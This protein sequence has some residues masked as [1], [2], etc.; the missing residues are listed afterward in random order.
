[1]SSCWVVYNFVGFNKPFNCPYC[2]VKNVAE[3]SDMTKH[4]TTWSKAK[5][6][7]SIFGTDLKAFVFCLLHALLQI[8]EYFM[9]WLYEKLDETKQ[10]DKL[11]GI[12]LTE[13]VFLLFLL[14]FF[15][16]FSIKN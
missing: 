1:M 8:I 7:T 13:V 9:Q 14:F 12:M 15:F 16:F 11:Y 2:D 4:W 6:L 5:K 3:R 10:M